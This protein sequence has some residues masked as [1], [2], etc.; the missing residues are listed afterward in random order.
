MGETMITDEMEQ[1]ADEA[2]FKLEFVNGI[3]VWEAFPVI[4][5]QQKTLDIQV[6]LMFHAKTSGCAC[7]SYSDIYIQFP[8]GSI[9]RPDISIFCE[10]PVEK[11]TMCRTIPDAVIEI[12]SKGYEKKDTEISLPFYLSQGIRDIVLFDPMTETARHY[13][14][15]RMDEYR[16]PVDL[17]FQCGCKV[18]I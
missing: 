10:E 8:E 7:L 18:T 17:I 6:S 3:P 13:H 16:S 15:G 2:G 4:R 11:D 5:H 9:K 14:Q 1:R 12:L